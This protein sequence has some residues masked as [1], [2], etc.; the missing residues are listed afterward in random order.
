MA[1]LEGENK[2]FKGTSPFFPTRV[3]PV[4]ISPHSLRCEL[5]I[6]LERLD[7]AKIPKPDRTPSKAR[8]GSMLYK[9]SSRGGGPRVTR[10]RGVGGPVRGRRGAERF[11]P[12]RESF[13]P[14]PIRR[15]PPL[16]PPQVMGM[17]RRFDDFAPP[18]P[19][20]PLP[21]PQRPHPYAPPRDRYTEYR[22]DVEDDMDEYPPRG[23]VNR[24]AMANAML[25]RGLQLASEVMHDDYEQEDM[26]SRR[27]PLPGSFTGMRGRGAM[28][29]GPAGIRRPPPPTML[30]P[31]RPAPP[32]AY[33][34]RGKTF[35]G[36]P[37]ENTQSW[38]NARDTYQSW[39]S[40]R[41]AAW[42]GNAR[43]R[44]QSWGNSRGNTYDDDWASDSFEFS[45]PM[46]SPQLGRPVATGSFGAGKGGNYSQRGNYGN[47]QGYWGR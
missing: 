5:A 6:L 45:S 42:E 33:P 4:D 38:G 25:E 26:Y 17:R 37:R 28:R 11:F 13:Y 14:R 12:M 31:H 7:M 27:E 23:R 9:N 43:E 47:S 10:G 3:I 22:R 20:R 2:V 41:D 29:G 30:P 24:L 39:G 18:P 19:H 44:G 35:R 15:E 8:I 16:P 36:N 1:L 46:A 32:A 34:I 40:T 21:P